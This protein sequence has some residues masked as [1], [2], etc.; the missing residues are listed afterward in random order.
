MLI[1]IPILFF[2]EEIFGKNGLLE[3]LDLLIKIITY[4]REKT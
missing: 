1:V 4:I 3:D 2:E